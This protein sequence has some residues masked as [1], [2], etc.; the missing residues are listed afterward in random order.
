VCWSEALFKIDF[1]KRLDW[2]VKYAAFGNMPTGEA[3]DSADG[4][5]VVPSAPDGFEHGGV[6]VYT[7]LLH[8]G[9]AASILSTLEPK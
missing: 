1:Q 4:A 3:V 2:M 8:Q 9:K 5:L 6:Y 7:V